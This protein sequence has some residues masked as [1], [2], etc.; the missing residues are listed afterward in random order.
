MYTMLQRCEGYEY[1]T[2]LFV[3]CNAGKQ[4]ISNLDR[5]TASC[6][7][8]F[9]EATTNLSNDYYPTSCLVF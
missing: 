9:Y 8:I 7:L 4:V 5:E 1:I 3:N 2:S 6:L